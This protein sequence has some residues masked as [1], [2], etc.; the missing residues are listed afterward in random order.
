[1]TKPKTIPF[2]ADQLHELFI[3]KDPGVLYWRIRP[4]G[5]VD[6]NKPAGTIRS[7][8]YC[9]IKIG[10]QLYCRHRLIWK[11]ST[12]H[13]PPYM[14]DHIYGVSSGDA[15]SNLQESNDKHNQYKARKR[16]T[17]TS[18]FIGISQRR[19]KWQARIVVNGERKYLG[20]FSNVQDARNAYI[21]AKDLYH[22]GARSL[23]PAM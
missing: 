17:N 18:G 5:R 12:R 7:D 11:L 14:I 13:E 10:G 23:N 4:S 3:E 1:M 16:R 20:S 15:F 6:I 21:D 9:R 2:T 22:G 8:G 19:A